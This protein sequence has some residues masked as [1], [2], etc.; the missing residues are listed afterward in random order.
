MA[1]EQN[2]AQEL[3]EQIAGDIM[4]ADMDDLSILGSICGSLEQLVSILD[5][6]QPLC[7]KLTTALNAAL[8]NVILDEHG[9]ADDPLDIV[10]QGTAMLQRLQIDFE[11]TGKEVLDDPELLQ[12]IVGLADVDADAEEAVAED[13]AA[14]EDKTQ[15]VMEIPNE[16][17]PAVRDLISKHVA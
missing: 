15:T 14:F 5:E 4:T 10:A 12:Q 7:A 8:E 1:E 3:I 17:V 11:R 13:E 6:T 16:L 2:R 9:E